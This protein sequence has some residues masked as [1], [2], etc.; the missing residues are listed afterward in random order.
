[1]SS[2]GY[3]VLEA[4]NVAEAKATLDAHTAVN[5]VFTNVNMPGN[6]TGFALAA[7]I[8]QRYPDTNVLLTSGIANST[9]EAE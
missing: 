8:H 9:G 3:R 5:L 7:W 4:G 1:L 2:Y 6:E